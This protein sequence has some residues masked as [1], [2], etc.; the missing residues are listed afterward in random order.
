M[1]EVPFHLYYLFGF[2]E[3]IAIFYFLV[4]ITRVKWTVKIG[5]IFALAYPLAGYFMR[6]LPISFGVHSLFLIGLVA[7]LL[8]Y[9][10]RV[11]PYLGLISMTLCMVIIILTELIISFFIGFEKMVANDFFWFVSGLPHVAVL[12]LSGWLLNKYRSE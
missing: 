12:F 3:S 8:H 10:Y 6:M 7:L 5:F 2:L 11:K 4:N 1:H 9:L